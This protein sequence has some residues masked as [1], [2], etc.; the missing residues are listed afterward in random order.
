MV[1]IRIRVA[2]FV[3]RIARCFA[4]LIAPEI[5]PQVPSV[6]DKYPYGTHDTKARTNQ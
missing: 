6:A 4:E 2:R 5:K 3:L 1:M